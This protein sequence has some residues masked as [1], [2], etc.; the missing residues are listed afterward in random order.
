MSPS[1]QISFMSNACSS[2]IHGRQRT[3]NPQSSTTRSYTC[4]NLATNA[5]GSTSQSFFSSSRRKFEGPVHLGVPAFSCCYSPK[6]MASE[7]KTNVTHTSVHQRSSLGPSWDV[8]HVDYRREN[9][10]R[11]SFV[12]A[13]D[14]NGNIIRKMGQFE[15]L[16]RQ[17]RGIVRCVGLR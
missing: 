9:G 14:A 7:H 13:R 8:I 15:R 12:I 10:E 1:N 6:H 4:R 2:S 17:N 3:G 5:R 11:N 16:Q